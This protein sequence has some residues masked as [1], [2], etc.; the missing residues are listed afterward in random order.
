MSDAATERSPG[1]IIR[2]AREALGLSRDEFAHQARVSTSMVARLELR[3]Q[4][5]NTNA[6]HR[7]A[8]RAGVPLVDLL[9]PADLRLPEAVG[10]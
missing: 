6:L 7:I 3:N 10:S 4:L 5:P 9:P 1:L 2:T 8:A